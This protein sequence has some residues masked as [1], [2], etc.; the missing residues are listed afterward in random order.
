MRVAIYARVSTSDGR[1]DVQNQLAQLKAFA[2][3]QQDWAI[4]RIYKDSASGKSGQ[5]P[6]FLRLFRDAETR[7]FD[8]VLFWSLDRLTREGAL[9]S[10]LYLDK[11][12]S[13]GI[14]YRS[15]TESY[16][17]SCGIFKE[18]V[19]GILGTIAKQERLRLSERTKAGLARAR[20]E[21]TVLGRPVSNV[22]PDK[23][24]LLLARGLSYQQCAERLGVSKTTVV[25]YAARHRKAGVA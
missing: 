15:F 2:E 4:H 10:L 12:S 22:D 7:K 1:Q 8:V 24:M 23:I 18:A 20:A 19:I 3:G 13:L 17:D 21:G 16:L 9:Q 5:R 14:A 11:L 25:R 6:E